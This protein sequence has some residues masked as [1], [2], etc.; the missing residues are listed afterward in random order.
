[1]FSARIFLLGASVK[2]NGARAITFHVTTN[3]V[4]PAIICFINNGL[5]VIICDICAKIMSPQ[6]L[7]ESVLWPFLGL[8]RPETFTYNTLSRK[9]CVGVN[10]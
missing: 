9:K 4:P 3:N 5:G 10:F 2:N 7:L 8:K 6:P 1:M